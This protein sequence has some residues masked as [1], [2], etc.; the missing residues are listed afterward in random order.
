MNL[1]ISASMLRHNEDVFLDNLTVNDVE[2]ALNV[3]IIP[4][5]NDGYE[6]LDALLK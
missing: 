4:V 2:N 3:R 5:N 1:L 6:L